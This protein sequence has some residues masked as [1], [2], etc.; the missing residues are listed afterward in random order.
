MHGSKCWIADLRYHGG[1]REYFKTKAEA[2]GR[3]EEEF[4]KLFHP[5]TPVH[6]IKT[7]ALID[8]QRGISIL[9]PLGGNLL[10]AAEFYAEHLKQKAKANTPL[11]EAVT[12]WLKIKT[13]TPLTTAGKN[14]KT[15]ITSLNNLHGE[16]QLYRVGFKEVN[17]W[18]E[19][20]KLSVWGKRDYLKTA[21]EF[22]EWCI[23]PNEWLTSNPCTRI[24]LKTPHEKE[25]SIL[26]VNETEQLFQAARK[27]D[28]DLLRYVVLCAFVGLRPS[29]AR[30]VKQ[31]DVRLKTSDIRVHAGKTGRF[32]YVRLEKGVARFLK[33]KG[34]TFASNFDLRWNK[35]RADLGYRVW[36]PSKK[37]VDGKQIFY[38]KTMDESRP[39]WPHDVM[40]HT[41]CSYH[42]AAFE[43]EA[44]TAHLAGH[45]V[46]ILRR[47]YRR[48]IPKSDGE[49]FWGIISST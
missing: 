21:K 42:L 34:P 27:A 16:K 1:K 3:A 43:N 47:H 9:E 45:D 23:F 49:K 4:N 44:L 11:K 2:Q 6:F 38:S 15:R 26:S 5:Q 40:R 14:I 13:K 10:K 41:Y 25:V 20:L 36:V 7:E 22:F 31:E 33:W 12:E 35:L 46:K 37:R 48:P 32:R 30:K 17:L 8:A 39:Q 28:K 24:K 19:G 29:E 18:I